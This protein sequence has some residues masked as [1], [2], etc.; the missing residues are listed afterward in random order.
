[1]KKK[2]KNL[3]LLEASKICHSVKSCDE[4]PLIFEKTNIVCAADFCG[5]DIEKKFPNEIEKEVEV[6]K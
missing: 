6:I 5:T 3:T 2:I 1:M 4:C